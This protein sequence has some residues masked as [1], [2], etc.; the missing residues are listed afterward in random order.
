MGYQN[1]IS[2]FAAGVELGTAADNTY[3]VRLMNV[4]T[5]TNP[6]LIVGNDGQ[7]YL[8]VNAGNGTFQVSDL[9]NIEADTHETRAIAL[10][11]VNGDG[12]IDLVTGNYAQV[13]RLYTNDGTDDPFKV[14]TGSDART[15]TFRTTS[16]ELADINS[17]GSLDLITGSAGDG[18]QVSLNDGG[19][20]FAVPA[21]VATGDTR[22]VHVE[23]LIGDSRRVL[24]ADGAQGNFEFLLE[25]SGGSQ[26]N[27]KLNFYLG[28]AIISSPTLQTAD[29]NWD[30]TQWYNVMVRRS[31]NELTIWRDGQQM[32]QTTSPALLSALPSEMPLMFGKRTTFPNYALQGRLDDIR[33]YSRALTDVEIRQLFADGW[34]LPVTNVS[35]LDNGLIHHYPILGTDPASTPRDIVG[36]PDGTA[37]GATSTIG[38]YGASDLKGGYNVDGTQTVGLPNQFQFLNLSRWRDTGAPPQFFNF[39]TGNYTMAMWVQ[40][41]SV[42]NGAEAALIGNQQNPAGATSLNTWRFGVNNNG[43][44]ILRHKN[45]Y[46]GGDDFVTSDRDNDLP[47]GDTAWHHVLATRDVTGKVD[48]YVDGKRVG[49]ATGL[50][51]DLNSTDPV[52]VGQRNQATSARLKA[53][54]DEIRVYDRA[55]EDYEALALYN[56]QKP[57]ITGN[58]RL[59]IFLSPDELA[60][61]ETLQVQLYS[62]VDTETP[63]FDDTFTGMAREVVTVNNASTTRVSPER[64]EIRFDANQNQ[65][66]WQDLQGIIK[67]SP[68]PA[69][70]SLKPTKVVVDRYRIPVNGQQFVYRTDFTP[71]R[72]ASSNPHARNIMMNRDSS[73]L[74]VVK[75]SRGISLY[76]FAH[77]MGHLMGAGHAQG[78]SLDTTDLAGNPPLMVNNA[79]VA[80]SP[81]AN[82]TQ[83][84]GGG[85]AFVEGPG[86]EVR[87]E[88]LAMGS[89]FLATG[90]VGAGNGTVTTHKFCTIMAYTDLISRSGKVT[91]GY[92]TRIPRFSGRNVYWQGKSTGYVPGLFMPLATQKPN[93]PLYLSNVRAQ[94]TI[95]K[96]VSYYRDD[97]GS[98]RT[99]T[100]WNE[101]LRV[102]IPDRSRSPVMSGG[103]ATGTADNR[104]GSADQMA[105]NKPRRPNASGS[106]GDQLGGRSGGRTMTPGGSRSPSGGGQSAGN[107]KPGPGAGSSGR[108]TSRPGGIGVRVPVKPP[109]PINP[110]KLLPNDDTKGSLAITLKPRPD[111]S[112]AGTTSGLNRGATRG[113]GETDAVRTNDNRQAFHGRSVWWHVV[114]PVDGVYDV[115]AGTLGSNIDTTL[116]VLLPGQAVPHVNDNDPRAPGPASRVT[117]S[118]VALK[119][120]QRI[121]FVI[122]GVNGAEGSIKLNV[123]LK[124]AAAASGGGN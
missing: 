22:I 4:T 11:D 105:S 41:V 35:D 52:W 96:I 36:T 64:I 65:F 47:L 123:R 60:L 32:A 118:A 89:H 58:A 34:E 2:S 18:V 80:F 111:Q 54:V 9:K 99:G 109:T 91:N 102:P 16:I 66:A 115:I 51:M 61:G 86:L 85:A 83:S 39:G 33:F 87:D 93:E 120:G 74:M 23:D 15:D 12:D 46:A 88:Y 21:T 92:Y 107:T 84:G 97:N 81:Y 29:L 5:D 38:R 63:F 121:L 6:D 122:D 31:V 56:R 98:G 100:G 40:N 53:V 7:N 114:V 57:T 30:R 90:M 26:R 72:T 24:F 44:L 101:P 43:R 73:H 124:R 108:N 103:G 75:L 78:D 82:N 59:E 76:T 113:T 17:D 19:G 45:D 69:G 50:N 95:G 116:G 77:E 94:N 104:G 10:G 106:G 68:N 55:F 119:A 1:N 112:L 3:A 13:N 42:P 20:N 79:M 25:N 70:D 28:G 67:L 110:G 8:Y 49:G 117:M 37:F 62:N 48:L 71:V 27:A 14:G